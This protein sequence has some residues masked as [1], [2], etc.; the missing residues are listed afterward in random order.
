M[1]ITVETADGLSSHLVS[2]DE[3][4]RWSVVLEVAAELLHCAQE[5]VV[6][7]LPDATTVDVASSTEHISGFAVSNG[8]TITADYSFA[9]ATTTVSAG[10]TIPPRWIHEPTLWVTLI[11]KESYVVLPKAYPAPLSIRGNPTVLAQMILLYG[12]RM[13]LE[14]PYFTGLD[15]AVL[16]SDELMQCCLDLVGGVKDPE[17]G[18]LLRILKGGL[19]RKED[20]MRLA[21]YKKVAPR[22][23]YAA[24]G[25]CLRSDKA[26]LLEVLRKRC[27]MVACVEAALF[28][29]ET[30]LRDVV[31]ID[32]RVTLKLLPHKALPMFS[33]GLRDEVLEALL[34]QCKSSYHSW[35]KPAA[36]SRTKRT[37]TW[38][39]PGTYL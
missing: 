22:K 4:A 13:L 19:V 33:A 17:K 27:R 23:V 3:A 8:D 28:E 32:P 11:K 1:E 5:G 15:P 10:G 38:Y 18:N 37:R 30:F 26:F 12:A 20:V 35:T 14:G 21:A 16:R 25:G 34:K 39:I 7:D 36:W 24:M 31:M 9:H 6:L 2:I 29:D